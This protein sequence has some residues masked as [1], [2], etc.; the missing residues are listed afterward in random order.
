MLYLRA[1]VSKKVQSPE[2]RLLR[3]SDL[4]KSPKLDKTN[5]L[6]ST[7]CRVGYGGQRALLLAL[8]IRCEA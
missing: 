2:P 6:V 8:V 4:P 3:S 1:V 5:V 7:L